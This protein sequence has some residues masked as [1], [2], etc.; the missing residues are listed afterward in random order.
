MLPFRLTSSISHSKQPQDSRTANRPG[1]QKA[2]ASAKPRSSFTCRSQQGHCGRISC[3]QDWNT[4]DTHSLGFL[5]NCKL[6]AKLEVAVSWDG[7]KR[8]GGCPQPP[9]GEKPPLGQTPRRGQQPRRVN[10]QQAEAGAAAQR[11]FLGSTRGGGPCI[12]LGRSAFAPT[13][14]ARPPGR[15]REAARQELGCGHLGP[16]PPSAPSSFERGQRPAG[17]GPKGGAPGPTV[18]SK[19]PTSTRRKTSEAPTRAPTECDRTELR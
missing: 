13:P 8:T 16:G 7:S 14:L 2:K 18:P 10:L 1:G 15:R 4:E 12:P 11:Q 6:R 19:Q 5:S 17:G 9:T 3:M